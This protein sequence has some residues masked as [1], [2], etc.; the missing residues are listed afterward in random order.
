MLDQYFNRYGNFLID[1]QQTVVPYVRLPRKTSDKVHIYKE[2]ISRLD[3]ISQQY[4]E[5]PFFGW[6][7][8]MANPQFSGLEWNITDGA[9][10][11]VP[12]PLIASLQD[13]KTSLD[14]HFYYY[15]R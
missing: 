5:T 7:I 13:Y 1:G 4:Y 12:F 14:N 9:V 8:L 3:K 2:G 10:L 6:L 15:G 11:I